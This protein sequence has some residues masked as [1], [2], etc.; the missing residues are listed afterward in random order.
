MGDHDQEGNPSLDWSNEDSGPSQGIAAGVELASGPTDAELA[1]AVCEGDDSAFET[2]FDRHR[3]R[4]V[5]IAGRFFQQREEI[6]DV[7]QECF[8]K[9]YFALK[10]FSDRRD[11][12][13]AAWLSKIT[14]NVCYDELRRRRRNPETGIS[15]LTAVEVRMI[16][17]LGAESGERSAE[18]ATVTRDLANKLL[19]CLSAEDRVVLVLLDVE[20]L[21]VAEIGKVMSW[22]SAKV[23]IRVFRARN[24]LRRLLKRF[25]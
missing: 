24:E 10:D 5:I 16:S 17:T 14:F 25:L 6:E 19:A 1:S 8:S 7:A 2:L 4:V 11:G 13:F 9:A 22:S 3:R 23:K 21:S 15:E 18:S 20:G 12:S